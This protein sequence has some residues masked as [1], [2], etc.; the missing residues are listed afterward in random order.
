MTYM[1]QEIHE[2]P[3]ILEKVAA[4]ERPTAEALWSAMKSKQIEFISIVARGTSDH[5]A[6]F[7]KYL[8]EIV[9]GK[10][11]SLAAPSVFTLYDSKVDLSKTLML[12]ISQSG[13]STDVVEV[14]KKARSMGALTAGITDVEGSTLTKVADFS[15]FC[16]AGEEKSVAATKTYTST[17]AVICVLASVMFEKPEIAADLKKVA[18]AMREV[19]KL[20]DQIEKVVERYRYMNETIIIARGINLATSLEASLKLSETCYVLAKPFSEADF[21]HGP[22]A[23][24]NSGFPVFLYAPAGKGFKPMVEIADKLL[25]KGAELI[26]VST[27]DEILKK[28]R[29]PIKI[30]ASV[31]EIYSP[32]LYILVAQLFA[33]YLSLSKGNNPDA[34]RGLNKI[35]LT[36]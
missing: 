29:T 30:N 26:I 20:E 23:T 35:T 36:M 16:H 25:E 10:V 19:F 12:G 31:D 34:P 14:V 15:L 17:M 1:L 28:A 33:Q 27:E 22:I 7:A 8:F 13:E 9:G 3:D 32:M 2:Q 24:V 5:A 4:L 18:D 6:T 11:V 21:Q